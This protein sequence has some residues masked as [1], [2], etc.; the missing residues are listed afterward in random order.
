MFVASFLTQLARTLGRGS[1]GRIPG[2]AL[3]LLAVAGL[4]QAQRTLP[5][6]IL[7]SPSALRQGPLGGVVEGEAAEVAG[8]PLVD[9]PVGGVLGRG[10]AAL[11]Q[12]A[13][14]DGDGAEEPLHVVRGLAE[15]P[16]ER[17]VAEV[18]VE[19]QV[20][21]EGLGGDDAVLD[22]ADEREL[23]HLLN[24][25]RVRREHARR[26]VH[27]HAPAV[28][29]RRL[30][31]VGEEGGAGRRRERRDSRV[32][33]AGGEDAHGAAHLPRDARVRAR[34][35]RLGQPHALEAQRVQQRRLARVRHADHEHAQAQGRVVRR[36][37]LLDGVEEARH[38]AR[39]AVVRE[40]DVGPAAG[41]A[42]AA[43]G[44]VP[45]C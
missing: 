33:R 11:E 20:V 3:V 21:G 16:V 45:L 30:V 17:G 1:L 4:V 9:D 29:G 2:L 44:R 32:V 14:A 28:V 10:D 36:R 13:G 27:V 34:A 43:H 19:Q 41:A 15:R 39:V 42:R 35:R 37:A 12:L 6:R 22:G 5:V 25:L 26:V 38:E 24:R 23:E 40:R 18:Q 7:P 31:A 8:A